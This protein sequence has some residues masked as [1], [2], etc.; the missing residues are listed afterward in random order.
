MKSYIVEMEITASSDDTLFIPIGRGV[1]DFKIIQQE[2]FEQEGADLIRE[3]SLEDERGNIYVKY[4]IKKQETLTVFRRVKSQ[5]PLPK[6]NPKECLNNGEWYC[7]WKKG[8]Y[9]EEL[10]SKYFNKQDEEKVLLFGNLVKELEYSF[11]RVKYEWADEVLE[12]KL[13]EDCLGLHGVLCAMLRASNV[14]AIVDIGFR[15]I[16]KDRPH[17]WLWYFNNETSN[18]R[19]VDLRDPEKK[20]LVGLANITPRFSVSLGTTHQIGGG[21]ASFVQYFVS[22]K[23]LEGKLNKS[24][25]ISMNLIKE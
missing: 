5:P 13:A 22:K 15:L 11:P 23:V 3:E 21:T 2:G 7:K 14:P 4:D 16:S 6:L 25:E 17:V 1:L 19:I 10:V 9:L 20:T 18:W 12:K 8:G 24:H